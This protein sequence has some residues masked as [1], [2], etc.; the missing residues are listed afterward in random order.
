MNVTCNNKECKY[1]WDY[2]GKGKWYASC[3]Q[4]H[5]QNRIREQYLSNVR[6]NNETS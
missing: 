2:K 5:N 1:E 3:P 4:C 6:G